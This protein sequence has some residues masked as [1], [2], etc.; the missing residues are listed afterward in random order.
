MIKQRFIT[1]HLSGCL[2]MVKSMPIQKHANCMQ[3]AKGTEQHNFH[4]CGAEE[5]N[6]C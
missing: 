4:N 2:L 5:R 1:K 3:A 6:A